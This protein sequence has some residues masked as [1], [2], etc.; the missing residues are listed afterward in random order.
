MKGFYFLSEEETRYPRRRSLSNWND[1][2]EGGGKGN[3][4]ETIVNV[5]VSSFLFPSFANFEAKR[6][7]TTVEK[8]DEDFRKNAYY[9]RT[10]FSSL[11]SLVRTINGK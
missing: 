11:Y 5:V 3:S 10:M 2:F 6:D 4:L 9:P 8:E 7:T 1:L